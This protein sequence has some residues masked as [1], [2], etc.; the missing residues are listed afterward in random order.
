M[1]I[2]LFSSPPVHVTPGQSLNCSM[3]RFYR[4][5]ASADGQAPFASSESAD[6]SGDSAGGAMDEDDL[7]VGAM[8]IDDGGNVAGPNLAVAGRQ[9]RTIGDDEDMSE[10]AEIMLNLKVRY[11]LQL[12][13]GHAWM[14]MVDRGFVQDSVVCRMMS[15]RTSHFFQVCIDLDVRAY[16]KRCRLS[17]SG[18]LQS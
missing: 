8:D 7:F 2:P 3:H 11:L 5:G 13:R 6:A 18:V 14:E 16:M 17:H 15:L 1:G 12:L 4:H 10:V 9:R